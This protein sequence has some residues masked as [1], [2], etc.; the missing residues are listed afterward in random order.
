M[1]GVDHQNSAPRPLR[2]ALLST[3]WP[4]FNRPSVQLGSLKAFVRRKLPGIGVD[5]YHV[6]LEVAAALGYD[7][8]GRISQRTW[9][10]ESPYAALLY[11]ERQERIAR[12]WRRHSRGLSPHQRSGFTRICRQLEI[13]TSRI[14]GE[15]DW[16]AY[17]LAG[18]TICFGQLASSLYF[19]RK[20]KTEAPRLQVVVGGSACAGTMGRSLLGAV[21]EIDFV[22]N[23]EGEVPLV[24]L[25]M[26]LGRGCREQIKGVPG[27]LSR[28]E[29]RD[30]GLQSNQ[31]PVLDRLP[32]PDYSDYFDRL[33][34][35]DS[36][37]G[38]LA[39]LPME[40][41]RGCWWRKRERAAER[42]G[43]RGCAFCG[44]NVQWSGYRAKSP[45]RVVSEIDVLTARHRVLAVSFVDNLL[46]PKDLRGLFDRIARLGRDLRLFAEVRATTSRDELAAMGAA[47]MQEVQVGIEALSSRLLRRLNKGTTALENLEIMKNCE[48]PGLPRLSGNLI[49][50][51]P[52]SDQEE[53]A[54]T[55]TTLEF[56]FPFRPLKAIPFW[57]GYGSPVWDSPET[58]G[59][60]R[61]YNHRFY[62]H[63]FPKELLSGLTLMMQG[64]VG[65]VRA[66]T[67]LWRPVEQKVKEWQTR[68][69]RLHRGPASEPV[70]SY[71]DGGDFLI[72]KERRLDGLDMT[73][74]L[75]GSSRK[76]YLFCGT[77]R[78][79]AAIT[80]RFP[81]FGEAKIRPFLAMMVAKRL[82][83]E[84]RG[85]YLSLAVP[86]TGRIKEIP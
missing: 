3:P 42:K 33:R 61:T 1:V 49:L 22:V 70:L 29:V 60:K 62:T 18:F 68:Y 16:R 64:Y 2:A 53:V 37:H 40:I 72:I 26:R 38:F 31:V 23:G 7:L 80:A 50:G 77:A 34:S 85:R 86:V 57:L 27:L 76:M 66:K 43:F 14:L 48:T 69:E 6:Y 67:R 9:L 25:L 79:L 45:R 41:S 36:Q 56:A 84:E 75:Q 44:L 65:N 35:F 5:A 39:K 17:R 74:R 4:L 83:F 55:L 71:R 15:V 24:Q 73:H 11:P 54:E 52:S 51:F 20:I 46:P 82:M 12:F 30:G 21:S 32:V 81:G 63:L 10:A 28:A 8:Y 19:I 59:L 47:G 78:S 58:F 13:A